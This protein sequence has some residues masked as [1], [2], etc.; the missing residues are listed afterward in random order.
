MHLERLV[1]HIADDH[2]A[3]LQVQQLGRPDR[4]VDGAVDDH[5]TWNVLL[6]Q[7][8]MTMKILQ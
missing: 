2:S 8:L 5:V 6:I 1:A 3:G 7:H 4:P